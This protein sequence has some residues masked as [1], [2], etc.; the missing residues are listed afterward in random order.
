MGV[1]LAMSADALPSTGRSPFRRAWIETCAL[2]T[3]PPPQPTSLAFREGSVNADSVNGR[4]VAVGRSP[5]R[6]AWIETQ[7]RRRHLRR[8]VSLSPFRRA[9]IETSWR[10]PPFGKRV[11]LLERRGWD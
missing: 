8:L 10:A 6:R 9:W 3:N 5:F 7:L 4:S 2:R 1:E 11:A